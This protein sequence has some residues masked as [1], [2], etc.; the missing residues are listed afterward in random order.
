MKSMRWAHSGNFILWMIVHQRL[1]TKGSFM[2][3]VIGNLGSML[4]LLCD[5]RIKRRLFSECEYSAATCYAYG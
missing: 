3:L 4:C 1:T 2:G 5:N